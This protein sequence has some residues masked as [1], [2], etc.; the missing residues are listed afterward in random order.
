MVLKAHA[1]PRL[2]PFMAG[3]CLPIVNQFMHTSTLST[4]GLDAIA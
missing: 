1:L 4:Y 2:P 3:A